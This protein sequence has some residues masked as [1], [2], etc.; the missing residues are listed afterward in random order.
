M[1]QGHIS[2][3]REVIS[4]LLN[5][6]LLKTDALSNDAKVRAQKYMS[7]METPMG[8]YTSNSKG[9]G[10]AREKIAEFIQKRDNVPAF[11]AGNIY[12]T[13]GAGEGVKLLF[14]MLIG[15][16]RDGIMIPIPQYPLYSALIT[17]NGGTLV[18]YYLDE[19]KN[20]ALDVKDVKKQIKLAHE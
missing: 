5:P 15:S 7:L 13:N 17:L 18:P 9:F 2:F 4:A 11:D 10:Y 12:L 14:N 8:A 16:K 20:W 19:A 6:A 3:N 1:G